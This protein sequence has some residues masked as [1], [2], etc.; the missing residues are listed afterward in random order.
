M[1][2][3][4]RTNTKD[5]HRSRKGRGHAL[6]R[7][8]SESFRRFYS[9][10]SPYLAASIAF[11]ALLSIFPLSL[12]CLSLFGLFIRK[13]EQTQINSKVHSL[14]IKIQTNFIFLKIIYISIS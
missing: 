14:N 2:R 13:Y 1:V 9:G 10:D 5:Q 4:L 6:S 7:V 11:Y 12:I 8:V 3:S